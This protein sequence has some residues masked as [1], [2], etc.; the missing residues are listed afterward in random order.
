M[1]KTSDGKGKG[2]ALLG[3]LLV[4]GSLLAVILPAK[5]AAR[6]REREGKNYYSPYDIDLNPDAEIN[7][8][9][10]QYYTDDAE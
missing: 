2:S 3:L 7:R 9:P 4:A 1:K 10:Q 6:R 8:H 5:M